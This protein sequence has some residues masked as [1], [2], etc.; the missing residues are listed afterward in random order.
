MGE[1]AKEAVTGSGILLQLRGSVPRHQ[2]DFLEEVRSR[3]HFP[4]L[5]IERAKITNIFFI[6]E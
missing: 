3:H 5:L 2:E 6:L 1:A 4:P